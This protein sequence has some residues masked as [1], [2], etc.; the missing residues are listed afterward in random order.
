MAVREAAGTAV[1][2]SPGQQ[3]PLN[4]AVAAAEAAVQDAGEFPVPGFRFIGTA[5]SSRQGGNSGAGLMPDRALGLDGIARGRG[6]EQRNPEPQKCVVAAH[7]R[8][9][10]G[11]RGVISV[12]A[13][14]HICVI[15]SDDESPLPVRRRT[16]GSSPGGEFCGM[17]PENMTLPSEPHSPATHAMESAH[18]EMGSGSPIA[19]RGLPPAAVTGASRQPR[20]VP[21]LGAADEDRDLACAANGL[22]IDLTGPHGNTCAEGLKECKI[23]KPARTVLPHA[24]HTSQPKKSQFRAPRRNL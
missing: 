14:P 22:L 21:S 3:Q 23:A 5:K 7:D 10:G 1:T 6:S 18:G 11:L 16:A 15:D 19:S 24:N 13:A 20:T 8:C 17:P 9:S 4:S 2:A 12:H